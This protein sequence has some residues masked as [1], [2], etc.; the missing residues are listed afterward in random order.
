LGIDLQK[1]LLLSL[2]LA[3]APPWIS[4]SLSLSALVVYVGCFEFGSRRRHTSS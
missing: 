3:V 1:A 4:L 2:S